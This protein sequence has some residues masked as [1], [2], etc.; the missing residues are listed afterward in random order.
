MEHEHHQLML[1]MLLFM[2]LQPSVCQTKAFDHR[3][4]VIDHPMSSV[5]AS[6]FRESWQDRKLDIQGLYS[7]MYLL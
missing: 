7:A 4:M 3:R 5:S 1:L 6:T 2:D